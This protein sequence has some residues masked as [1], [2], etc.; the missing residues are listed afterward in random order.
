MLAEFLLLSSDG[1][2]CAPILDMG[3]GDGAVTSWLIRKCWVRIVGCDISQKR[4]ARAIVRAKRDY[5]FEKVD[6]VVCDISHLPFR[7]NSIP[8]IFSS[9]V[10]EHIREDQQ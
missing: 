5:V 2:D 7:K 4:I 6:F 1:Y 8:K 3:C 9:E 10:L